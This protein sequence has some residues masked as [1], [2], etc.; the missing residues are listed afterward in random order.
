MPIPR[1]LLLVAGLLLPAG[2]GLADHDQRHDGAHGNDVQV[3]NVWMRPP[4][5][6]ARSVAAYLTL[7]NHGKAPR[8]LVGAASQAAERVELHRTEQQGQ[9]IRMVAIKDGLTIA[10]GETVHFM[11]GGQHLMLIGPDQG[12][13]ADTQIPIR[14]D[15]ADGEPITSLITV[16]PY[17][18]HGDH[19]DEQNHDD[20]DDD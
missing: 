3:H 8:R 10:P 16:R 14:L 12:I 9:L 17:S 15:F 5:K 1:F 13:T 19:S 4:L 6:G 18:D 11:P 20:H 7:V 2:S